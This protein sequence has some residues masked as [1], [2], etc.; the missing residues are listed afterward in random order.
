VGWA[1]GH[2]GSLTVVDDCAGPLPPPASTLFFSVGY[3][4]PSTA[5]AC[6]L[7]VTATSLEGASTQA[8][9]HYEVT[10]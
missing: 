2:P 3:Q 9:M 8:S 4:V 6:T 7:T 10:P 5:T 1:D